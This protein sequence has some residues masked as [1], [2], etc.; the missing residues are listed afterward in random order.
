MAKMFPPKPREITDGSGEAQMFELL[1]GLPDEYYVFHSFAIVNEVNDML[2]ESET[3]F[4][5]FHPKKGILC[6]EAKNGNVRYENNVWKYGSG[7]EMKHDGPFRQAS[8]NKHNLMIFFEEKGM[9]WVMSQCKFMH[10]VWFPMVR[11]SKFAGV[12]LPP[13]AKLE[14]MLT[15]DSEENIEKAVSDLMAVPVIGARET[16]LTSDEVSRIINRVLAPSFNLISIPE[17]EMEFRHDA[18]KRMLKEQLALLNYLEEQNT[19]VINGMA[20]TGK[21]VVAVEKARRHAD[22][23]EK[24]LFL[25]YN[26]FLKEHLQIAY[27]YENVDYYTIDGLACKLCSTREPNYALLK[28]KLED[29]YLEGGFPYDHIVIDE[30]QDFG[31]D[32]IE[33]EGIISLLR[34]NVA[35]DTKEGSFY[36]FYDKNQMIQSQRMPDYIDS[37]DCRLTLYRNCRNTEN[38]ATTSL[39]LLGTGKKPKLFE[40]AIRGDLAEM[41]FITDANATVAAVNRIIEDCWNKGYSDIVIL[42]CKTEAKSILSSECAGGVYAYKKKNIPFTTCRKFKGLEAEVIILVDVDLSSFEG[43]GERLMYVG[44]SRAKFKLSIIANMGEDDCL[45]ALENLGEKKKRNPGKGIATLLNAKY[46]DI[47]KET[48]NN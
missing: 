19:A 15:K 28:E 35:D 48:R 8:T 6:L 36:L 27:P 26:S 18:F 5:I 47:E 14:L 40:G 39:R 38:I 22:N 41:R 42:T 33:E 20:G 1:A 34:D 31:K 32:R 23:G 7:L 11:K 37:A 12:S 25:C 44:S 4:V 2:K 10:G 46:I 17:M 24:V 29:F 43:E 16:S 13:E 21:T 9:G 45:S 3:D 30:G